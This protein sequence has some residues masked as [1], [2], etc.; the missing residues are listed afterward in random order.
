MS[1][2]D[3]LKRRNV[4]RVGV[5]YAIIAWLILQ[6]ADVVLGNIVAPDWVFQTI[7]LLLII[8][9]P[10][11]V[12]FAWAFELTPQGM[13]REKDVEHS[14]SVTRKTGRNLDRTIIVVLVVALSF[15]AYDKFSGQ[16]VPDG[17]L[18]AEN[19][20]SNAPATAAPSATASIVMLPFPIVT[21][22]VAVLP[23]VN[24]S[25]DPEQEYFSD[26][27]S[28]ELLNLLAK[29]PQFRVAGRTSSF[30]F[31]GKDIDLREIGTSLG[32]SS[33]LEGSVR[34]GGERVRITA[35]LVNA[36]D[37]FHLWSETYDRELSDIFAVQ[38]EIAAAVVEQLKVTLLGVEPLPGRGG[39]PL[40]TNI[41]AYDAFL[42]GMSFM[43]KLGPSNFQQ[44]AEYFEQT[45][46]LAPKSALAWA[47][48]SYANTRFAS[49]AQD[50]A[51][52]A[53]VRARAAVARALELDDAVPEAHIASAFIDLTF[54]WNWKRAQVSIERA[55]A[56]RPGDVAAKSLLAE[57][58][59]M[60]GDVKVSTA[61]KRDLAAQDPLNLQVQARLFVELMDIGEV[62]ESETLIRGLLLKNPSSEF[63]H[64]YL[65][66]ALGRQ[67]RAEEALQAAKKESVGFMRL[68]SLAIIHQQLGQPQA[69]KAAQQ[70]LLKDYGDRAA[71]QQAMIYSEWGEFD[72]AI[73]W[74][75]RAYDAHDAGLPNIK[76]AAAFQPLR[77]DPR[78]IAILQKMN[79]ED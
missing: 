48:L 55:L 72:E 21:E 47:R 17:G 41:E 36:E 33:I 38:D 12:L 14:A 34:K 26:G 62:Q 44:A 15:F 54:E 8:G 50:G 18:T 56:L 45:V 5:M 53:L 27:I 40:A 71:Y 76:T 49:Q 35:Q 24:M 22:S 9:F 1:F 11:A 3:E 70:E 65:S 78:Y 77:D 59:S 60:R 30:A 66:Y 64:G 43:N 7:L 23:F 46:A 10:V 51:D 79:L 61:I 74:L 16:S 2:F 19:T 4:I 20:S 57:L 25:S 67:G 29:I 28:E 13:K 39:E 68:L 31:K 6:V 37:G 58:Y 63:L 52:P 69:A 42:K 75:E 32:V 73:F